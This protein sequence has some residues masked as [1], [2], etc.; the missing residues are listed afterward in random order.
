MWTVVWPNTFQDKQLGKSKNGN[1][2]CTWNI[3]YILEYI[4]CG[5][6]A[7]FGDRKY[8]IHTD[9]GTCSTTGCVAVESHC[10]LDHRCPLTMAVAR[11]F[12]LSPIRTEMPSQFASRAVR[13]CQLMCARQCCTNSKSVISMYCNKSNSCNSAIVLHILN[14]N[15]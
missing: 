13:N 4:I 8:A 7:H 9:A 12:S 6:S 14:S 5:I 15:R 11:H 1:C 3:V 10:L 2:N